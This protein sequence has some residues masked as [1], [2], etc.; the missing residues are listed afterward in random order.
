MMC[1]LCPCPFF[2]SWFFF[3]HRGHE[4][5]G[6]GGR[7]RACE[8]RRHGRRRLLLVRRQR[9]LL[10]V[11]LRRAQGTLSVT[12]VPSAAAVG[13]GVLPSPVPQ[14]SLRLDVV[15]SP[16]LRH[17]DGVARDGGRVGAAAAVGH[18]GDGQVALRA[19]AAHLVVLQAVVPHVRLVSVGS[20]TVSAPSSSSAAA[21][22]LRSRRSLVASIVVGSCCD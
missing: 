7:S 16:R 11:V 6:A 14:I 3:L 21:A 9:V 22:V 18:V 10:A 4:R 12:G 2:T 8:R 17:G 20:C 19:V 1:Q 15:L 5:R 13:G